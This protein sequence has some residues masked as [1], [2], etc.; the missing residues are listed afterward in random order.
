ME[1]IAVRLQSFNMK[2][3]RVG[4]QLSGKETMTTVVSLLGKVLMMMF[5]PLESE[6]RSV[7]LRLM[8]MMT[9]L[10]GQLVRSLR[11]I[12]TLDS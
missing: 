1:A 8:R 9:F 4:M 10:V 12:S 11:G 3:S 7:R 6:V 5:L 2:S